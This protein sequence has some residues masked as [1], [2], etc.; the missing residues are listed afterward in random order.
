MRV[1]ETKLCLLSAPQGRAGWIW[2][3]RA[4]VIVLVV[5]GGFSPTSDH[6]GCH[7]F[8][9]STLVVL[10]GSPAALQP[11]T[12]AQAVGQELNLFV[13]SGFEEVHKLHAYSLIPQFSL[14]QPSTH[15]GFPGYS[16]PVLSH[17]PL[18]GCLQLPPLP[19]TAGTL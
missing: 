7:L 6:A 16:L 12:C 17:R 11:S 10:R 3:W 4:K 5:G 1:S 9:I 2:R 19:H 14:M 13:S 8:S 15:Q 18:S